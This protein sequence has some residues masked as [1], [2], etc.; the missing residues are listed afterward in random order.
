VHKFR[1]GRIIRRGQPESG[2]SFNAF[3]AR[4]GN[5]PVGAIASTEPDQDTKQYST[6]SQGRTIN[7]Y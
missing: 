1:N 5:V 7:V 3:L 4:N 6:Y 2:E